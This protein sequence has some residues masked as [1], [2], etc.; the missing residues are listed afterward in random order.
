MWPCW[1]ESECV[2]LV[3]VW[4]GEVERMLSEEAA[5]LTECSLGGSTLSLSHATQL[6]V[7]E[8]LYMCDNQCTH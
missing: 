2:I 8:Q 5:I 7:S 3:R 4:G 6:N 1:E